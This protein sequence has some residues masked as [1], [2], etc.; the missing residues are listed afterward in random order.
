MKYIHFAT[1]GFWDGYWDVFGD[2]Y[3]NSLLFAFLAGFKLPKAG[4]TRHQMI[5]ILL[6]IWRIYGKGLLKNSL[7]PKILHKNCPSKEAKTAF[8]EGPF[9]LL[10]SFFVQIAF[11]ISFCNAPFFV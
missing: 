10:Y 4:K 1:F 2:Y 7:S 6:Q 8:L 3:D 9:T 5:T 11:A